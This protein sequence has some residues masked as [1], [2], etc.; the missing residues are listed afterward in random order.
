M[1]S[2]H[3]ESVTVAENR[4]DIYKKGLGNEGSN[5]YPVLA[6]KAVD[7]EKDKLEAVYKLQKR[8]VQKNMHKAMSPISAISGYLE[9]MK[10]FLEK[11]GDTVK[12]EKYRAKI[13]EGVGEL[14]EIIEDLYEAFEEDSDQND[15]DELI[16][17]EIKKNRRAS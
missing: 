5:I 9:L 11:G 17:E 16:L 14:S 10:L 1:E 3:E 13:E 12:L 4:S 7:G 8:L 6:P 2:T 15:I